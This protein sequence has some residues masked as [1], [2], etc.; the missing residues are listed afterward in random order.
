MAENA[1]SGGAGLLGLLSR[2]EDELA[3]ERDP[4]DDALQASSDA[5]F[6]AMESGDRAAFRSA[7]E[8]FVRMSGGTGEEAL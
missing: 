7:L 8:R 2:P 5:V 4:R 6:D 3:P 1:E